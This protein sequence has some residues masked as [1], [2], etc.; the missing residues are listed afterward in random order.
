MHFLDVCQI[1]AHALL[2]YAELEG[3]VLLG[4]ATEIDQL[5][6]PEVP[7]RSASPLIYAIIL[8]IF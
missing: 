6:K 5:E 1:L 7:S 2:R 3:G 8:R 4:E